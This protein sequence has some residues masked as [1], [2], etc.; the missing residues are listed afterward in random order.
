MLAMDYYSKFI[1][2]LP[3]ADASAETVTVQ[4]K[5]IFAR[6][7]IP[8]EMVADNVPF[9]SYLFRRFSAE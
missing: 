6:H 3:L 1:E 2:M 9:N 5:S 7:G 4:L 8:E